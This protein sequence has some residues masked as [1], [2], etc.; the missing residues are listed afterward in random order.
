MTIEQEHCL[1][2]HWIDFFEFLDLAVGDEEIGW[3]TS[4]VKGYMYIIVLNYLLN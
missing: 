3:R 1:G 2:V 4:N